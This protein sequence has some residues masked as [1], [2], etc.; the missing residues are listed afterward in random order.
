MN[1]NSSESTRPRTAEETML[2]AAFCFRVYLAP[3]VE[4]IGGLSNMIILILVQPDRRTS[5]SQ[6]TTVM[7]NSSNGQAN[8]TRLSLSRSA[9]IYFSSIAVADTAVLWSSIFQ[10]GWPRDL[11]N[12]DPTVVSLAGCKVY[13]YLFFTFQFIS[14]WLLVMFT[15][16]RMLLIYF[17]T[18]L[19]L[20]S[21]RHYR[22]QTITNWPGSIVLTVILAG[23]L[24]CAFFIWTA[25]IERTF[26]IIYKSND[27][28]SSQV[29]PYLSA[30]VNLYV[31]FLIIFVLNSMICVRLVNKEKAVQRSAAASGRR[32][33]RSLT[34][35][36]LVITFAF[37]LLAAP[38]QTL[39]T[40]IYARSELFRLA[41]IQLARSA[42][43][44][45]AKLHHAINFYFYLAMNKQFRLRFALLCKRCVCLP[46][47]CF[48]R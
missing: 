30:V 41:S 20:G 42:L 34:L 18:G 45:L 35:L 22:V 13:Q 27:Q 23:L 9:R 38:L 17:P 39:N 46:F 5:F 26:C 43:T 21:N 48:R 24:F 11:F 14:S 37:L 12:F 10:R 25:S 7:S 33:N 29:A 32:S 8:H 36:L 44:I 19:R 28:F 31:P 6:P 2:F 3:F 47:A 16:E 15:L 4:I 40:I 1:D